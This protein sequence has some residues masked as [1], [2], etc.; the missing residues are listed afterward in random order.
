MADLALYTSKPNGARFGIRGKQFRQSAKFGSITHAGTRTVRFKQANFTGSIVQLFKRFFHSQFLALGVRSGD[1]LAFTVGGSPYCADNGIYAVAI[2]YGVGQ[3]LQN[4][5]TGTFGHYKAVG[6]GIKG[7]GAVLGQST[8]FAELNIGRGRHHL[9]HP[10]GYGHIKVPHTQPVYGLVNSRQRGGASS[11][12]RK[13]GTVQIKHVGYA[14]R[15]NVGQFTRHR[16]FV[17]RGKFFA[18]TRIH[19]V[20]HL[21]GVGGSQRLERGGIFEN[22]VQ[23]RTVQ[24]GVGH[25][26]LHTAHR[27]AN[28]YRRAVMVI[29][30]FIVSGIFQSH[31]GSF[32]GQVLHRVH[33]LGNLRRNTVF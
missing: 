17:N 27:V 5:H 26:V 15:N 4:N 11:I 8:D 24:A 28:N 6:A 18:H 3:A 10:A 30:F 33:L 22:F 31:T 32:N 16:I 21:L 13:V 7:I 1:T 14:A 23:E 25:F 29:G 9:V 12:H 19:F 2:F 20:Q